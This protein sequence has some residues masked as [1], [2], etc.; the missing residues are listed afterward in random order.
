LNDTG[1][2]AKI[3]V[4]LFGILSVG[5]LFFFVDLESAR[6]G[7]LNAWSQLKSAPAPIYFAIM[8]VALVA[9]IPASALYITAG[10]LYG[11]GPSLMWIAPALAF[12]ALLVHWIAGSWLRPRL[13]RLIAKRGLRI[14]RLRTRND[15][16]LFITLVRITPGVPYFVQ[17]WVLALSDVALAPFVAI[18]VGIQML[19]AA[20]FVILGPSAFEG[21]AGL[22][23]AAIALL[24]FVSI[25]ARVVHKRFRATANLP[26]EETPH[27]D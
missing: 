1:T 22:A 7:A 26:I 10:S 8:T 12:N 6:S 13:E 17:N 21:E 3:V 9:P 27:S 24:V 15:E 16:M 14:P 25:G 4:G 20:G 23:I 5:A 2:R 19:F 11:I 18:S